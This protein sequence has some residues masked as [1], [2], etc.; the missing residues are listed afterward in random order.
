MDLDDLI[1]AT[2]CLVD[3]AMDRALP[4]GK[5]LRKRGPD[6]LLL[7]DREVLTIEVVGEFLGLDTDRGIFRYFGRH[8]AE[9][10]PGLGRAHRTTFARQAANLWKVKELLW[11]ELVDRVDRDPKVSLVD[12]FSVPV[13]SFAKAPRHKSFAGTAAY[14]HDA[15]R[16][17][18]FYGFRAHLRV[19]WPGVIVE[20][21]LAPANA[22][23]RWVAESDL[24]APGPGGGAGVGEGSVVVGDTNYSSPVLAEDLDRYGVSLIAPPK[25]SVKRER[26]PW[27]GWLTRVR[28]RIETVISQ[29]VERYRIGR[30]RARDLWHLTSR[31]WRKILSHTL[32]VLLCQG[33]GLSSPLRFSELITH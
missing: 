20:A 28:R 15:M 11:R 14:G 1:V 33:A 17:A 24:L 12:S 22:H 3:E 10:F 4:H 5:R 25:T 18:V 2:Y 7:D 27:P 32:C 30:V 19:C 9:W 21:A 16:K 8:Y 31:F 29:L 23:D 26:H 13:C 6:P